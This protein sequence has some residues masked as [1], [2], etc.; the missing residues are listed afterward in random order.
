[1]LLGQALRP[2]LIGVVVGLVLSGLVSRA[3]AIMLFGVDPLDPLTSW[4]DCYCLVRCRGRR[5][6]RAGSARDAR[7]SRI[8]AQGGIKTPG[9]ICCWC[10]RENHTRCRVRLTPTVKS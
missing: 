5:Q 10:W 9:V 8:G 6:L 3:I 4:R 2:A 7:Q 1:M